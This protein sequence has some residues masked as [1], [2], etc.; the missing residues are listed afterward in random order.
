MDNASTGKVERLRD[1]SGSIEFL[2]AD[3]ADSQL[4]EDTVRGMEYVIHQAA[5]PSVLRSIQDPVETNR[6][7][8]TATLNLLESC[9]K[10]GVCRLDLK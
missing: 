4:A 9:R 5:V 3:L 8:V 10:Q 6:A 2:H 7:N 1:I